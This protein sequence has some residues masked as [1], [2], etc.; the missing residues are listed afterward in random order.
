MATLVKLRM[1]LLQV[2][3]VLALLGLWQWG[4]AS[5]VLD[6][7]VVGT[8]G[9]TLG[10]LKNWIVDGTL[11]QSSLSTM[12]VL[13]LGWGIGTLLGVIIGAAIGLNEFLRL[14]TDP[15]ITFFNGMPRLILYPFLAVWLGFGL[16]AKVLLVVL[17]IVVVVITI[18]ASGFR[19]VDPEL[20]NN[21]KLMGARRLDIARNVYAPAL[22]TWLIGSARVT[23]GY[24]FQAS[25]TAEFI[26]SS[27]GLGYLVV[28][29]ESRFNMNEIW[30]ALAAVIAIAWALDG[31]IRLWERRATRWSGAGAR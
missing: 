22:A 11:L 4:T 26:G 19:D 16:Q 5:G 12:Q 29:G 24:A 28:F 20:I 30:A 18:V 1:P 2:A 21:S 31:L 25:I 6:T 13:L 23:L 15:F 8:P 10:Q 9:E 3:A 27:K 17:V 7:F 14:V